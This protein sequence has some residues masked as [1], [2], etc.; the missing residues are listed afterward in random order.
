MILG[1]WNKSVILSY[2]GLASAV[3]G[4]SLFI[5]E[6]I[7]EG[8]VCFMLSG[9]CD[10]FDGTIARMCKRTNEEKKF[11]IQLDSIIDV[12]SFIALPIVFFIK[13][14]LNKW[15]YIPVLVIYSIYA[16]A[17]LAH[18]NTITEPDKKITYYHGLPLTYSA[19]IF[20][21]FYLFS[22]F[23]S[24]FLFTLLLSILIIIVA[25][26]YILD[27]KVPKPGIKSSLC[28]FCLGIVL[29]ILYLFVL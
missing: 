10:L 22:Y 26:L 25:L 1:K 21:V 17:R 19:L 8:V 11:G 9:V 3:I 24:P 15:Y 4:I 20:C 13:M 29:T 5:K 23:V 18:F 6:L 12:M 28:L 27:V 7:P 2:V 14:G 16:V